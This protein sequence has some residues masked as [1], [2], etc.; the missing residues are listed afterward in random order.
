MQGKHLASSAA[1]LLPTF[2]GQNAGNGRRNGDVVG[3][4]FPVGLRGDIR[5]WLIG[6]CSAIVTQ[7]RNDHLHVDS[8]RYRPKS[9]TSSA[10]TATNN[11]FSLT[12]ALF[13]AS[14][15]STLPI[16]LY[17]TLALRRPPSPAESAALFLRIAAPSPRCSCR[18]PTGWK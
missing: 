13:S 10:L 6:C 17:L 5:G 8:S 18:K 2:P 3:L 4:Q 15:S 7:S 12:L 11:H 9:R 16:W 1:R 14:F